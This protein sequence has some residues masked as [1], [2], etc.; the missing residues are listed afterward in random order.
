MPAVKQVRVLRNVVCL[1]V[2]CLLVLWLARSRLWAEGGALGL[3]IVLGGCGGWLW[4]QHLARL[5][6][7][8]DRRYE[9]N[10]I[11]VRYLSLVEVAVVAVAYNHY[12]AI[13]IGVIVVAGVL[14][15]G[16]APSWWIVCIGSS[17]VTGLGVLAGCILRYERRE[18]PLYYQYNS[19]GWGGAEGMLYQRGIVVQP[20]L[21]S[22]KVKIQGV[23]W[24]AVSL[25]GTTIDVGEQVEVISTE[26]LTLYVDRLP[27]PAEPST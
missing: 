1:G 4:W 16:F 19:E 26:C 13:P 17:S 18:G 3:G 23:L 5:I 15:V 10:K 12:L 2:L 8:R 24:N 25:N 7:R 27:S 21:P 11:F 14:L 9:R 20:L 22:G 6:S